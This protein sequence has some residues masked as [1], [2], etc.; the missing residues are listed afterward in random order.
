MLLA[1]LAGKLYTVTIHA[2]H[3]STG[4]ILQVCCFS[5]PQTNDTPRHPYLRRTARKRCAHSMQNLLCKGLGWD[6]AHFENFSHIRRTSLFE[7]S[8]KACTARIA[9]ALLGRSPNG[10]TSMMQEGT[11]WFLVR[12]L[13]GN[14]ELPFLCIVR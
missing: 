3:A 8:S 4:K 11:L 14:T 13:V 5:I 6:S 9:L 12:F 7:Q 1:V 10:W 2:L